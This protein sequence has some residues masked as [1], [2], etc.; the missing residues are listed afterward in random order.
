MTGIAVDAQIQGLAELGDAQRRMVALGQRPRPIWEAVGNYGENST[1]LRF[2]NQAGP[3]RK[4]WKPS[5]RAREVGGQTLVMKAR[6]LRSITHKSDDNGT[7]WGTNVIYARVQND[8]AVISAKSGGRL[9][10]RLPGGRFVTVSKVTI[11]ARPFIG[12][13]E[14]DVREILAL[15]GEVVYNAARNPSQGYSAGTGGA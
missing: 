5:I 10:F 6:L 9:R 14:D 3:D 4:R 15:A 13:N 8:G 1:R 2:K 7:A 12:I 11:P